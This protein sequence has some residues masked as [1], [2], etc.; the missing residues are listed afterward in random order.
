MYRMYFQED[1]EGDEMVLNKFISDDVNELAKAMFGDAVEFEQINTFEKLN[2]MLQDKE[3][4][5]YQ[6]RGEIYRR[7]AE[8]LNGLNLEIPKEIPKTPIANVPVDRTPIAVYPG[9]FQP[10][11][12]GHYKIY[13]ALT[14]RFGKGNVYITTPEQTESTD[15]PFSFG[16]KVELMTVMFGIPEEN[17]IK[18]KNPLKPVE[19]TKNFPNTTPVVFAMSK[20]NAQKLD[21]GYFTEF[22][23]GQPLGGH[24]ESAYVAIAPKPE[25]S[26]EGKTITGAQLRSVLGSPKVTDRAKAE[27]F[28]KAYG[29]FNKSIF[30]KT[31][32][33]ASKAE[34]EKQV[35]NSYKAQEPTEEI[36]KKEDDE[37]TRRAKAEEAEAE[38]K[39]R[40]IYAVGETWTTDIGR[41]GAKNSK[42]KIAY[43]S[44]PEAAQL[45]AHK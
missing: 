19:L 1:E 37:A 7:F 14:K 2:Q 40:S 29:K 38:A 13:L 44:T 30:E 6:F 9:N 23:E 25:I 36:P 34:E 31:V 35:T 5:L 22:Q 24:S 26:I 39:D 27:L 20:E 45:Y 3:A 4:P 11:N 16:Q 41:F 12:S 10:F 32:K 17:I 8:K 18:T 42:G 21:D 33:V 28:T 15:A 43:F